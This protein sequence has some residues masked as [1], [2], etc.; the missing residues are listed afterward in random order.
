M[1]SLFLIDFLGFEVGCGLESE[2]EFA[3]DRRFHPSS[4]L[5]FACEVHFLAFLSLRWVRSGNSWKFCWVE[6]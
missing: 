5:R 4:F 3:A 2:F 6:I 1:M